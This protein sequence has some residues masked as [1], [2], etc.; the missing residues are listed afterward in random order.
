MDKF[1]TYFNEVDLNAIDKIYIV[2]SEDELDDNEVDYILNEADP[3]DPDA[4]VIAKIKPAAPASTDTVTSGNTQQKAID[5]FKNSL[6]KNVY[7]FK[8][9][10]VPAKNAIKINPITPAPKEVEKYSPKVL[11]HS[12]VILKPPSQQA[13]QKK[14]FLLEI[15]KHQLLQNTDVDRAIKGSGSNMRVFKNAPTKPPKH[16]DPKLGYQMTEYRVLSS[17]WHNTEKRSHQGYVVYRMSPKTQ[18]I[19]IK[20]LFCDCNDFYYRLY[21]P[22]ERKGLSP[23]ENLPIKYKK[24]MR[25]V[26]NKQWTDITNQQGK[27]F[28]CKHLYKVIHDLIG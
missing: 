12:N 20:E 27:L 14:V 23:V 1:S 11:P 18:T 26:Y 19:S 21:A 3:N 7:G 8:D 5:S 28:L 15:S 17:K 16:I 25:R 24:I 2:L 13:A 22:Y 9:A 4:P 10:F 6:D